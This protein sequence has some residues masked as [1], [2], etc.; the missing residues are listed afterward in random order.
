MNAKDWADLFN[1]SIRVAVDVVSAKKEDWPVS[2]E[3]L[4]P[5]MYKDL[6]LPWWHKENDPTSPHDWPNGGTRYTVATVREN[7]AALGVDRRKR[8]L[9]LVNSFEDRLS[10]ILIPAVRVK[11]PKTVP[12]LM[13]ADGCHRTVALSMVTYEPRALLAILEIPKDGQW[14][15]KVGR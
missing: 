9:G 2:V 12:D 10:P 13:I 5:S 15:L 3:I 7:M 6:Q 8:I 4:R 1:G 14:D 11:R